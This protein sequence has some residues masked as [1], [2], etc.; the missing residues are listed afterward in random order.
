MPSLAERLKHDWFILTSLVSKDFKLKYRR[1]VL[2]VVWSVLNPLLMMVVMAAVFSFVFRG[3]ATTQPFPVYLILGT[4]LFNLMTASTN[5][6][7]NSIIEAAGLIK[8]IRVNKM[9]F[10]LE[11][12][13]FELVNF[14]LSLI[15]VVLVMA[16]FRILPT[17]NL[18]MLP[19]LLLYM[20][21]FCIGLSFLLSALAV[22]FQDIIYLWGVVIVAWTYA[23][24]L[25]YP[26]S[27]LGDTMQRLMLFNPMYHYVTYFRSITMCGAPPNL[28]YKLVSLAADQAQIISWQPPGLTENLVCL[29]FAVV[30][31]AVGV[32]VFR[33]TQKRFVLFV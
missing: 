3:D 5:S 21:V 12:V 13:L 15:A 31:L 10:P 18:L 19:L 32:V 4:S 20:L 17:W 16:I 30:T 28:R 11:K 7:A 29:G 14:A 24:P 23:T 26:F 1:S 33:S 27:I 22:F 8:K 6:G 2:G 25:F 9:L